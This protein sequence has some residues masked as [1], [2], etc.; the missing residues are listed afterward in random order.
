MD[1]KKDATNFIVEGL[2]V[3]KPLSLMTFLTRCFLILMLS[4]VSQLPSQMDVQIDSDS[5]LNSFSYMDTDGVRRRVAPWFDGPGWR[6][7]TR[8]SVLESQ[9]DRVA[10]LR[11]T[12]SEHQKKYGGHIPSAV[13]CLPDIAPLHGWPENV[14]LVKMKPLLFADAKGK[15]V[16]YDP[17]DGMCIIFLVIYFTLMLICYLEKD[18][19]P[20]ASLNKSK[21]G[22]GRHAANRKSKKTRSTE[23]EEKHSSA[24]DPESE[25]ET[26]PAYAMRNAPNAVAVRDKPCKQSHVQSTSMVT[27]VCSV[28]RRSSSANTDLE[29]SSVSSMLNALVEDAGSSP[30]PEAIAHQQEDIPYTGQSI[31]SDDDHTGPPNLLVIP[32]IK[33]E[34]R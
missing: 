18:T 26:V 25:D 4:L 6:S 28:G 1:K 19:H 9:E 17:Y 2:T 7:Q 10:Q 22:K 30:S 11:N 3:M 27:A 20:S 14:P 29:S 8:T 31:P 23:E 15:K 12:W 34:S 5:F 33:R 24:F 32:H 21:K 16:E 13:C